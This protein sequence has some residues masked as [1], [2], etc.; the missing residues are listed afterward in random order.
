MSRGVL[1]VQATDEGGVLG[2]LVGAEVGH[3]PPV[4]QRGAVAIEDQHAATVTGKGKQ[5]TKAT[6]HIEVVRKR[7]ETGNS[8][9]TRDRDIGEQ[10]VVST[11]A[12]PGLGA[13]MRGGGRGRLR[14]GD[15]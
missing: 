12:R 10:A 2:W 13:E 8:P 7:F 3:E 1:K 9:S 5:L 4:A 15:S 14:H 11:T 6:V